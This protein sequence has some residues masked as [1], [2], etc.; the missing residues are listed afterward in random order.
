MAMTA[1][2]KGGRHGHEHFKL[3]DHPTRIFI[4]SKERGGMYSRSKDIVQ[5]YQDT[6]QDKHGCRVYNYVRSTRRNLNGLVET[7]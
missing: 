7:A 3:E 2:L 5:I 4:Q 1:A 6:G